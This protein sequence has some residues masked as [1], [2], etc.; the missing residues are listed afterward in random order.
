[1]ERSFGC[2]CYIVIAI[3]DNITSTTAHVTGAAVLYVAVNIYI[4]Y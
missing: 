3:S 1:M 4:S 2:C